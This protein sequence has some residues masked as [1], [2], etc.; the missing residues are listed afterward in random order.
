MQQ[1]ISCR[2]CGDRDEMIN[3]IINECCKLTQKEYKTIHKLGG[4]GDPLEIVQETEVW[5]Y[6]QMVYV[7]PSICPGEWEAQTPLG[8]GD[9]NGSPNQTL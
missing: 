7:Q 9:T 6:K 3:H 2:L 1:N 5:P 4:Q 8:F